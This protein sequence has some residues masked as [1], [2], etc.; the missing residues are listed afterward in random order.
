MT[1]SSTLFILL[2]SANI[3]LGHLHLTTKG[4]GKV[5]PPEVEQSR[6]QRSVEVECQKGNPLG[7]SYSG[8]ENYTAS[9]RTCQSWAA[10][11][12]HASKYTDVGNHNHCRNP[13]GELHGVWCYTLDPDE[14]WEYCSVP[15][16]PPSMLKVLHFSADSNVDYTT[17]SLEA[18][19]L[20]ESFTI[21]SAFMVEAFNTET[22]SAPLLAPQVL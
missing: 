10:S 11:E 14:Q 9:G 13:N 12:P 5:E 22:A 1:L 21:C 17:A 19:P 3:V 15:M 8:K 4:P 2:F 16:C 6:Q 7:A 20:P 18:G